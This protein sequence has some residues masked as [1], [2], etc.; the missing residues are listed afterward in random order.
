MRFARLREEKSGAKLESKRKKELRVKY[1]VLLKDNPLLKKVESIGSKDPEYYGI[2]NALRPE[3]SNKSLS[4]ESEA[5]KMGGEWERMGAMDETEVVYISGH[6]G[7]DRIYPKKAL[8][9]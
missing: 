4:A 3:S 9:P 5:R 2:I 6:D 8:T 1:K 7:I